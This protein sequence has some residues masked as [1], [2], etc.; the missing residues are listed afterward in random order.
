MLQRYAEFR[1]YSL[2]FLRA[3]II[4]SISQTAAAN[5]ILFHREI[6]GTLSRLLVLD[7]AW[8]AAAFSAPAETKNGSRIRAEIRF[9]NSNRNRN[10]LRGNG[11]RDEIPI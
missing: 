4:E 3:R 11:F 10:L 1:D 2:Q 5:A 8:Q 7:F 9:A 6:D